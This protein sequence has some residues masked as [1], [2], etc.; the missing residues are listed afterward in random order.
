MMERE[1]WETW[2][3]HKLAIPISYSY[4]FLKLKR[5]AP[6]LMFGV[7]TNYLLKATMHNKY[8]FIVDDKIKEEGESTRDLLP[9]RRYGASIDQ[10]NFQVFGGVE[11]GIL[12][13]LVLSL[14]LTSE[15]LLPANYASFHHVGR[16][17]S[18]Y[19]MVMELSLQ[20]FFG[21]KAKK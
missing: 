21:R 10:L 12:K 9:F 6:S 8:S 16:V 15:K 2:R 17:P 1:N 7:K 20:Y 11:V 5:L 19:Y 13:R 14:F 4:R 3:F 18:F